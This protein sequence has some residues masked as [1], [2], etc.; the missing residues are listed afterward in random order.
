MSPKE[1]TPHMLRIA[2][3]A[4][5]VD[6]I[7]PRGVSDRSMAMLPWPK[8]ERSFARVEGKASASTDKNARQSPM[9][10]RAATIKRAPLGARA[11]SCSVG[12]TSTSREGGGM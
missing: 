2:V 1:G 5:G 12:V 10:R 6:A 9:R 3:Q 4:R 11:A 8:Y 7:R